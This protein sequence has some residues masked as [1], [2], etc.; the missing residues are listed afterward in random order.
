MNSH[1]TSASAMASAST[2]HAA[3]FNLLQHAWPTPGSNGRGPPQHQPRQQ[4][5][6]LSHQPVPAGNLSQVWHPSLWNGVKV[7]EPKGDC[8][9]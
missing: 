2:S 1:S 9:P 5:S 8:V 4:Q 3:S 7:R 6:H